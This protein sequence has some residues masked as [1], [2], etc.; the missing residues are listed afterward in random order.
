MRARRRRVA[1]GTARSMS[2]QVLGLSLFIMLLAF[3][4][5]L[6]AVSSYEETKVRPVLESLGYVFASRIEQEIVNEDPSITQDDKESLHEGETV[7]RL[8]ALFKA[9]LPNHE[10]IVSERHGTMH[11]KLPFDDFE[12][13]V[14]ALGQYNA[15]DQGGGNEGAFMKGFFL[16]TLVSLLRREVGTVDYRMDMLLNLEGNPAQL[17]NKQPKKVASLVKRM[18]AIAKKIEDAGLSTK[19]LSGGLQKG[20]KD[21]VE[22]IFRYHIPYDPSKG[23]QEEDTELD[24]ESNEQ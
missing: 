8:Q 10:A 3:F 1:T 22:L 23:L 2:S 4:I 6:N 5:V 20:E 18:S 12:A 13:A 11:V 9:Q 7:E 15:L 21:M 19:L 16:P 14:M 24:Q 17:Q